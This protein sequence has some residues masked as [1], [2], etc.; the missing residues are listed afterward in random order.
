MSK[1]FRWTL[2]VLA[3]LLLALGQATPAGAAVTVQPERVAV[4]GAVDPS[5]TSTVQSAGGV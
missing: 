4:R 3:L 2:V 5:L 1:P